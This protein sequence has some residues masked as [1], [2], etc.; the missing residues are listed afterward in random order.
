MFEENP[1]KKI[2]NHQENKDVEN[3]PIIKELIEKISELANVENSIGKGMTAE[4]FISKTNPDICYKIIHSDGEYKFRHSVYDE[5]E[6][7]AKAEKISRSHGIKI[8][9]PYYSILTKNRNGE[10]FEVLVMERLYATSIKDAI[11]D[12]VAVPDNFDF[13]VF[14]SKI[15]SFFTELHNKNIYHRDAHGGNIM[16]ENETGIP[17]I[18][19]FGASIK[20]AL[21]NED[22]YQQ[23]NFNGET[24][25]FTPDEHKIRQELRVNLR[26]F[27]FKKYGNKHNL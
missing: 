6:L 22:P 2:V 16:I 1:L 15:E 27:L 3:D 11:T 24:V 10:E 8:P 9:K 18:I 19:D 5:G 13:K 20:M 23:I 26:G 7:L 12:D 14:A 21:N 17:C 4:V 25:I